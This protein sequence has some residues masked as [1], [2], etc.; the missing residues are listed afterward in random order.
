MCESLTSLSNKKR[1]HLEIVSSTPGASLLPAPDCEGC[2]VNDNIIDLSREDPPHIDVDALPEEILSPVNLHDPVNDRICPGIKIDIPAGKSAHSSYPFGLHDEFGD[3]WNYSVTEGRLALYSRRCM[4][5]V[6]SG[7]EQCLPCQR[8]GD[9]NR[10]QGIIRRMEQGVH[11]NSNLVYHSIGG[12]IEIVRRKIAEIKTLKLKVLND[13]KNLAGKA[14][15]IDEFKQWVMAVGSGRVERVDRLVRINLARRGGIRNLL[16]LYERAAQGIYKPRNYTE[17]DHLRGLLL[18]QLGGARLAG[19]GHR[20][21]HLPSLSTLRRNTVLPQLIVSPSMPTTKEI[22]EN[23]MNVFAPIK[24]LISDTRKAVHQVLMFDEL[25]VE[26]RPRYDEKTNKI[27]GLCREHGKGLEFASEREVQV[28]LESVKNK[29]VH[30]AVDVSFPLLS[31]CLPF[32]R[33][34]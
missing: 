2:A 31:T 11:E 12:L 26:E 32:S 25:K 1:S 5:K 18:W 13:A 19:I 29:E 21:L 10:L 34:D 15:V 16:N 28:L 3:P 20:A 27:L 7:R 8:L 4:G 30:L 6:F 33:H 14:K 17:E 9:D 22:M 24:A 23:V